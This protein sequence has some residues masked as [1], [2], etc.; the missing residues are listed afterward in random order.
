[1]IRLLGEADRDKALAL[2]DRDHELNLIMIYDIT[3]FGI[4]DRGIPSRGNTTARSGR[5]T[6]AAWPPSSISALCSSTLQ[7]PR[8]CRNWWN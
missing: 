8:C 5:E 2:L 1:M 4:E 3:H 7:I 6:S